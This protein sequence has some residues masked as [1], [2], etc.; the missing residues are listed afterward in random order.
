MDLSW[1][2]TLLLTV[3]IS[4]FIYSTWNSIYRRHNLPPGPTPLPIVGNVLH[5]KRGEMVKS[6]ME[7]SFFL[8]MI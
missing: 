4:A 2:V 6:L 5:I 1:T 7:V 3:I 8:G